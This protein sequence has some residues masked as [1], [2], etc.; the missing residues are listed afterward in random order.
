MLFTGQYKPFCTVLHSPVCLTAMALI[1]HPDHSSAQFCK[2]S[3]VLLTACI[4]KLTETS[5]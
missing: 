2:Y 4:M 5:R 1:D 3:V